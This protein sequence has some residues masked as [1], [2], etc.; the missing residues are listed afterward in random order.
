MWA[1]RTRCNF[2]NHAHEQVD[3]LVRARAGEQI[4][5]SDARKF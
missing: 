5:F 2:K 1:G 4:F 3:Q